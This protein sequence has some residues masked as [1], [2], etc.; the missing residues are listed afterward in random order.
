MWSAALLYS[1]QMILNVYMSFLSNLVIPSFAFYC[2]LVGYIQWF[3]WFGIYMINLSTLVFF[4][5]REWITWRMEKIYLDWG[6]VYV[7]H[8]IQSVSAS[9]ISS[10]SMIGTFFEQVH[11]G[12]LSFLRF[13]F[14]DF[15]I[16]LFLSNWKNHYILDR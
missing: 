11:L 14:C 1:K 13:I 4:G 10:L 16:L 8:Y 15:V 2:C 6:C 5:R 7:P 9:E 3:Y 12:D